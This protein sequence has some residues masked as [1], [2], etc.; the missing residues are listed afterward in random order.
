MLRAQEL[1]PGSI[2]LVFTAPNGDERVALFA[3]AALSQKKLMERW[4][5][6]EAAR[7]PVPE[8]FVIPRERVAL[9]AARWGFQ[10]F[11]FWK[12]FVETVDAPDGDRIPRFVAEN[13]RLRCLVPEASGQALGDLGQR[14]ERAI[15]WFMWPGPSRTEL[16][17]WH[18]VRQG[19]TTDFWVRT[20][21]WFAPQVAGSVAVG[22]FVEAALACGRAGDLL[23]FADSFLGRP[24]ERSISNDVV[25]RIRAFAEWCDSRPGEV[26][27][28]GGVRVAAR[29]FMS[30]AVSDYIQLEGY[31]DGEFT[32]FPGYS[33]TA[34]AV[35]DDLWDVTDGVET[36]RI[37]TTVRES[38]AEALYQVRALRVRTEPTR[39]RFGVEC[40]G[41]FSGW[42]SAGPTTSFILWNNG[43]GVLVDS[44]V[45]CVDLLEKH[46][47]DPSAIVAII[48]THAHDDHMGDVR[49][50]LEA[51]RHGRQIRWVGPRAVYEALLLNLSISLDIPVLALREKFQ[52]T[53]VGEESFVLSELPGVRF[54]P[55]FPHHTIPTWG[56]RAETTVDGVRKVV[57]YSSDMGRRTDLAPMRSAGFLTASEFERLSD[58]LKGDEDL[59]FIDVGGTSTARGAALT[60]D[61]RPWDETEFAPALRHIDRPTA[62]LLRLLFETI[63]R[64]RMA[65]PGGD[66]VH[67]TILDALEWLYVAWL[68]T[69]SIPAFVPMHIHILAPPFDRFTLARPETGVWTLAA[70]A[71]KNDD[72]LAIASFLEP[73]S[74]L[75]DAHSRKVWAQNFLSSPECRLAPGEILARE[76]D[77]SKDFF[78]VLAGTLSVEQGGREVARLHASDYA[79]ELASL[80]GRARNATLKAFSSARVLTV[81]P[82]VFQAWAAV[83]GVRDRF[84]RCWTALI[85]VSACPLLAG[86]LPGRIRRLA[87][88]SD[89][90]RIEKGGRIGE[91]YE[92]EQS[93]FIVVEGA[94]ATE[95]DGHEVHRWNRGDVVGERVVAPSL[96]SAI[97]VAVEPTTVF[98]VPIDTI[99]DLCGSAL[100]FD[101]RLRRLLSRVEKASSNQTT[102][103]D[104][105]GTAST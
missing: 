39:P 16:R 46:G 44:T 78:V 83:P 100:A 49:V 27:S 96:R 18:G 77:A 33:V 45:G 17:A 99:V 55:F 25:A 71:G 32:L 72:A 31:G 67:A 92:V 103:R 84:E 34:R 43:L 102:L 42:T 50:L 15:R 94:V 69:D 11:A 86:L 65:I 60:I 51:I 2:H 52:A 68:R 5:A 63:G 41:A 54:T 90:R 40:L 30:P 23:A 47:V 70:G 101:V 80:Y 26:G 6:G 98:R 56:F 29:A 19:A 7:W 75:L 36:I 35:A 22:R 4:Q 37:D 81:A 3:P 105:A 1:L 59:V 48:H 85:A 66:P 53:L 61:G 89:V 79:G 64:D 91:K 93:L 13:R 88:M 8:V 24:E 14:F 73:F 12:M 28:M 21:I 95:S 20:G 58:P 76:G 62:E 38:P 104:S 57:F 97:P 82:D 74:D 9:G 87:A 10:F